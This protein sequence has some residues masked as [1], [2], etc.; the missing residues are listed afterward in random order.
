[1]SQVLEFHVPVV[2]AGLGGSGAG[3]ETRIVA[4][5][6]TANRSFFIQTSPRKFKIDPLSNQGLVEKL[7][8]EPELLLK[9]AWVV[10]SKV[11]KEG[12][13][14]PTRN[15]LNFDPIE[16]WCINAAESPASRYKPQFE[17]T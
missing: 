12:S 13:C 3:Q 5:S 11:V 14:C 8:Q 17:L 15:V 9:V 1:M 16:V 7:L 2:A 6:N 4:R 10:K